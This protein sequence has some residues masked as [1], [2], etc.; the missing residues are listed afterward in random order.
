VKVYYVPPLSIVWRRFAACL[1]AD[2]TREQFT[3]G[4][5]TDSDLWLLAQAHIQFLFAVPREVVR[6]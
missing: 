6:A 4:A 3:D 2:C 1:L 5:R